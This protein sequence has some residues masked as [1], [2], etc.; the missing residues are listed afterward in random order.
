MRLAV[1]VVKSGKAVS[2]DFKTVVKDCCS[3][4][5]TGDRRTFGR[6][7]LGVFQAAAGALTKFLWGSRQDFL[8]SE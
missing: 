1:A 4:S 2:I 5:R 3:R 7:N 8:D 6:L